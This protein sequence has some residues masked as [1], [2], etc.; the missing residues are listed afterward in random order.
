MCDLSGNSHHAAIGGDTDGQ[1]G[2]PEAPYEIDTVVDYQKVGNVLANRG[3]KNEDIEN[4][5][6]RNWQRFF[7]KWLPSEGDLSR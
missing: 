6:Y 5:M 2:T 4:I 1:G 3:F 7:E